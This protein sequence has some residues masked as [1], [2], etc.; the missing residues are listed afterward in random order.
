MEVKNS[1]RGVLTLAGMICMNTYAGIGDV[2]SAVRYDTTQPFG[3]VLVDL[4]DQD[5]ATQTVASPF[6][7]NFFGTEYL[8]ICITTNGGVYPVPTS[9]DTCSDSY[10][11]NLELLAMASEAPM[12]AVLAADQDPSNPLRP[13]LGLDD[14]QTYEPDSDDTT[15]NVFKDND[16]DSYPD[17]GF[18]AVDAIYYDGSTLI[19]G[20][21]S[22]IVT[23]Y[24]VPMHDADNSESLFNTFQ[25]VLIENS[26]TNPG[27]G[28]SDFTIEFNYGSLRD[29][30]DG[31]DAAGPDDSCDAQ[32]DIDACRYAVGW[33]NYSTPGQPEGDVDAYE[34]Y[35]SIPSIE[36][37]D[38]G[39]FPLVQNSLNSPILGR[40][41]MSMVDGQTVG[42]SEI[43][44]D[45]APANPIPT[46]PL[47]GLLG[48][49]VGVIAM[50]RGLLIRRT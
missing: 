17:D 20:R 19:D 48:L 10:N 30:E 45:P 34:F 15:L 6:P 1:V 26:P 38:D 31:Y 42:F 29:P 43:T 24:R 27:E 44:A 25:M 40:Y 32:A 4:H 11:E 33:A 37:M 9:T 46:L 8:G 16:A 5:D 18:G 47:F 50:A 21:R 28:G 49:G 7:I 13:T 35:A 3:S 23:W 41:I 39:S 2:S 36:L 12:I 14:P 22:V